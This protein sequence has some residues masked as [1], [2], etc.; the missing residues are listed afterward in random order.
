[1]VQTRQQTRSVTPDPKSLSSSSGDETPSTSSTGTKPPKYGQK[2]SKSKHHYKD[3]DDV[4]FGVTD[5]LRIIAGTILFS[6][7][8]SYFVIGDSYTW[9]QDKVIKRYWKKIRM[10]WYTP[11]YMDEA[12]LA[13]YNGTDETL[14]IYLS[15]NGTIYDVTEGRSKYGPGGGYS[16]FAGRDASRAYITGN[17]K[18]DLTWDLSGIDQERIDQSLGHWARFFANHETYTFVGYLV[19]GPPIKDTPRQQPDEL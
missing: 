8:V 5:L 11:I 10:T 19:H 7:M 3:E 15:I 1:M 6:C 13:L 12:T 16:F 4:K 9:G 2:K 17:F 18:D 14:P